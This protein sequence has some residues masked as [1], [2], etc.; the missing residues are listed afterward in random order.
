MVEPTRLTALA[1]APL[2]ATAVAPPAEAATEP[3]NTVETMLWLASAETVKSSTV[4]G[5]SASLATEDSV[6]KASMRLADGSV[7]CCHFWVSEKSWLKIKSMAWPFL[8]RVLTK[9]GE[10]MYL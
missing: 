7:S 9:S 6:T 2:K 3:A 5:A 10:P 4:S 1:P 8:S